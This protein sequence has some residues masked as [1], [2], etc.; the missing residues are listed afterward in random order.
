MN[1]YSQDAAFTSIECPECPVA[2]TQGNSSIDEILLMLSQREQQELS[3]FV[4]GQ[5]WLWVIQH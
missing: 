3:I 4:T 2:L 1:L 5:R